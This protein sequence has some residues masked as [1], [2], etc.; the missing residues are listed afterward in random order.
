MKVLILAGG[1][2]TRLWPVS[3]EKFPKQFHAFF[4]KSTLLEETVERVADFEF[5]V[6]TCEEF[7][8]L[9]KDI[10]RIDEEKIIAEPYPR[11]TAPA[12][13]YSIVKLLRENKINEK[14]AIAVIPSDHY[15][16]PKASFADYLRKAEEISQEYIVIFGIKPRRIETGYGYALLGDKINSYAYKVKAFIEKPEK[17]KARELI[18]NQ[19]LWNSG[20]FVFTPENLLKEVKEH[21]PEIYENVD[22]FEE[23]PD[24]AIDKAIIEKSDKIAC[25]P[26]ALKWSD[27]GSWESLYEVEEK[28]A[29]NNLVKANAITLDTKNSLIYSETGKMVCTIGIKDVFIVNTNDVLLILK[30]GYGQSVK[31]VV[32]ELKA[33]KRK[34]VIE[35][36]TGYRPWGYYETIIHE[37]NYKLKKIVVYPK[38]KLS[39]QM[40]FHR[41]EHWII[42]RGT[43]NVIIEGKKYILKEGESIF[44]P[45]TKKHRIENPGNVDLEIIEIQLGEYLGE[46]DIVRFEDAYGRV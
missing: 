20:I 18:K 27:L 4:M 41:S 19:A 11:N 37:D 34:E 1:K 46:D 9:V 22:K 40:H 39:Y 31:K 42:V 21:A 24:M 45:K 44:V 16:E 23:M 10:L 38:A 43:A 15:L 2:G 28:D 12:I 8:T 30:K 26:L 5:F 3:R 14:E 36:F 35:H 32:N 13:V 33:L 7:K 25:I 17:E 6:S 29:N